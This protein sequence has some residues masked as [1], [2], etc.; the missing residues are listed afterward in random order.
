MEGFVCLAARF[1]VR[2]GSGFGDLGGS[3]ITRFDGE[4]SGWERELVGLTFILD[5]LMRAIPVTL[6]ETAEVLWL[7]R[8]HCSWDS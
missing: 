5:T 6:Y 3:E 2:R 7:A 4:S 8:L 1:W